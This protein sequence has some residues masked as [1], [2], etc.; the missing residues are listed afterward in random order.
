MLEK[1]G[2]L[3]LT[4]EEV[5]AILSGSVPSRVAALWDLT[6]EELQGIIASGEYQQ[7]PEP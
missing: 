5:A 6:L 4:P 1:N 2:S 3:K 7:Q